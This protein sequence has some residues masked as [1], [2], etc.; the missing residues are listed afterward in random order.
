MKNSFEINGKEIAPGQNEVVR[1]NV[2]RL[3]SGT[4]ISLRLH[5]YRSKNPG[6]TVLIMGGVHGDEINGVEIVRKAI[7]GKTF[8]NLKAGTVTMFMA[9]STSH[10]TPPRVKMSTEVF[11]ETKMAHWL[12]GWRMR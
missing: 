8:E 7:V 9:L 4:V 10:E 12:L 6:P 1:L 5:I 3:P 2:A 11:L